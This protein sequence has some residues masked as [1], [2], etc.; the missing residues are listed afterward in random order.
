MGEATFTF[1]VEDNL[2]S[3]F[4]E[5]AKAHD[6]TGAQLLRSFMRDYVRRQQD[7]AEYDAWFRLQVQ[8]GL[9]SANAGNLIPSE[10]VEAEFAAR[11]AETRRKLGRTAS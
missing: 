4:S 2:K 10:D 11:R 5:A 3:A 8:V 1:R 7:E 9:D 6:Q